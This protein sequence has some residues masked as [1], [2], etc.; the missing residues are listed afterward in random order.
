MT[1]TDELAEDIARQRRDL[2]YVDTRDFDVPAVMSVAP[3][4]RGPVGR[5]IAELYE[6]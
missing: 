3:E 5:L 4:Q 2:G 6:S 1:V